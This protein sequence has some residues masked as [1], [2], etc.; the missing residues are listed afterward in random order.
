MLCSLS[1]RSRRLP[2]AWLALQILVSISQSKE[3][4][5]DMVLPRYLKCSK[6]ASNLSSMG[7]EGGSM[8]QFGGAPPS[9]R[10]WLS[11][12]RV[13]MPRRSVPASTAGLVLR[14]PLVVGKE[15][16]LEESLHAPRLCYESAQVEDGA[17]QA[18]MNVDPLLQI[19]DSMGQ[20]TGEKDVE[21]D[22]DLYAALLH[23]V[24]DHESIR[25]IAIR[26]D[27]ASHAVMEEP[28]HQHQLWRTPDVFKDCP[29]CLPVDGVKI[30]SQVNKYGVEGLVLFNALLL[31]LSHSKYHVYSVPVRPE[32]ALCLRK[33]LFGDCDESVKGDSR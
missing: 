3:P 12:Q 33:G 4:S 32:A 23:A 10:D 18:V 28:D 21:E 14:G 11:G 13:W 2:S 7:G 8:V 19:L 6:L 30:F 27:L 25:H 22:L 26:E 29:K 20:H 16:L 17:I 1:T 9:F 15:N 31:K 5:Q 24:A